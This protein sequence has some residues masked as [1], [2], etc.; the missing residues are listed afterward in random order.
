MNILELKNALRAGSST[1]A[2]DAFVLADQWRNDLPASSSDL[3]SLLF[4][5]GRYLHIHESDLHRS[6]SHFLEAFELCRPPGDTE[7]QADIANFAGV[8]YTLIGDRLS[9]RLWFSKAAELLN[10]LGEDVSDDILRRLAGIYYNQTNLYRGLEHDEDRNQYLEKSKKIYDRLDDKTGQGNCYLSLGN[11]LAEKDRSNP[12]RLDYYLKALEL[13]RESAHLRGSS[14]ALSNIGIFY[15]ENGQHKEGIRAALVGILEVNRLANK[16]FLAAAYG[17]AAKCYTLAGRYGPADRC[18]KKA[19]NILLDLQSEND[20]HLLYEE[21]AKMLARK[22]DYKMAWELSQNIQQYRKQIELFDKHTSIEKTRRLLGQQDRNKESFLLREKEEAIEDYA[23][24]LEMSNHE[25]RQ[26]A[27]AAAHDLREPIRTITS[28]SQLMNRELDSNRDSQLQEYL[29]FVVEAGAQIK[30]VTDSLL[31][32]YQVAPTARPEWNGVAS[33]MDKLCKKAVNGTAKLKFTHEVKAPVW[34][35]REQLECMLQKLVSN[36]CKFN[37]QE[38]IRIHLSSMPGTAGHVLIKVE[39]NGIGIP[40]V[41]RESVFDMFRRLHDRKQY[42]GVGVGLALC[43]KVTEN[44]G[45]KIW[46]EDSSLGG[47]AVCIE[48][49]LPSGTSGKASPSVAQA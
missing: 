22:G 17:S 38:E 27:N 2:T 24:R 3:A 26:F 14:A 35:D 20:L 44:A 33:L 49:P 39:D 23:R 21:W 16:V 43:K 45:G 46:I 32:L 1:A 6:L 37:Q 28:Y 9:A 18:F 42:P 8:S 5:L 34:F 30:E 31:H 25:L 15:S 12:Q 48:L 36:A 41:Y 40:S 47:T 29:R 13:F 10:E 11:Y 7:L 4:S 19:E